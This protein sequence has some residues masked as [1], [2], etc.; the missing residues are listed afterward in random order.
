MA[1]ARWTGPPLLAGLF[2]VLTVLDAIS[3]APVTRPDCQDG[4]SAPPNR[5]DTSER[6]QRL[7]E[8]MADSRYNID[9]YIVPM[10]DEHQSE[11]V[12]PHDARIR[13]ISGFSGSAG[14]AIVTKDKA[15][16][17]TDGRYF[18]QA[19]QEMDCNW[20]LMRNGTE[21]KPPSEVQ[22]LTSE[23]SRGSSVGA[24]PR[25]LAAKDWLYIDS[26][27][28][29]EGMQMK[30]AYENLIDL[31]W[32]EGRPPLSDEPI[33]VHNLT[34]AGK[35]WESKVEEVRDYMREEKVEVL[36]VS[37][38]DEVA[39]LFNLRGNDI[40]HTPVFKAYAVIDSDSVHLW[41][42]PD[43]LTDEVRQHLRAPGC[44]IGDMCVTLHFYQEVLHNF[45]TYIRQ[46]WK[47]NI[48]LPD[49]STFIDSVSFS[50]YNQV[51]ASRLVFVESPIV[52][53]KGRK[54]E[55]EIAGMKAAN[56]R[57]SVALCEFLAFME[58]EIHAGKEWDEISAAEKL[59]EFRA[60]QTLFRGI[61]FETISAFGSNGAVIHYAPSNATKLPIDTS[62]TYLLDSGGQYL[63]GTTDVTRTI[64]Y[65]QPTEFQKEA[66]TR[67]LMGVIDLATT[68]VN[69]KITD[70]QVQWLNEYH[71]LV[72]Q[73]MGAVLRQEDRQRALRWLTAR[74]API[75]SANVTPSA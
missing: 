53:M 75:K 54:N 13:F 49:E 26:Q 32:T 9:A 17:W 23:L 57:D 15:A 45:G 62:S 43:K 67:V 19:E 16:L 44:Q 18:L 58:E 25:L 71:Q 8:V 33:V 46:K 27:L 63:D 73:E 5:V 34:Y 50:F 20:E 40:P 29:A 68:V 55:V 36:L 1:R 70:T 48:L 3:G 65:G 24:D 52:R 41:V 74:T 69:R 30:L 42:D 21:P 7:R 66:Y 10:D 47:G 4:P 37:A 6:L 39:W 61:S 56:K 14:L 72:E 12:S 38:L 28:R 2:V 35:T 64:H 59:K 22:W 11:Y 60:E 51:P 31:I